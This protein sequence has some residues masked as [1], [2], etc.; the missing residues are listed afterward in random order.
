MAEPVRIAVLSSG[1]GSNFQALVD[2]FNRAGGPQRAVVGVIASRADAGVLRRARRAGV[3]SAV[4]P[5]QAGKEETAEFLLETLAAWRSD[6]VVLAGYM[7]L[8][9][10]RVVRAYWGRI[11]NI[12]PALLPAFGGKGM[13]GGRVHRAVIEAGT[14]ITGATVHF[15]DEAYDRGPI[16]CQWPVPVLAGD[17]PESV[18]AR[19]LAVEHQILPAAV[20]SLAAG[21]VRLGADGRAEWAREW[22]E[23]EVFTNREG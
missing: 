10:E 11:V 9:P 22:F 18:A 13:Y 6:I 16:L 20:E 23:T 7:K 5:P 8:V 14:R 21:I 17:T 19:V 15:V 4:P 2:R 3:A 12:H 1:G